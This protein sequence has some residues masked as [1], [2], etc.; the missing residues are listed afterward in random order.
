MEIFQDPSFWAATAFVAFVALTFKP[1][2]KVLGGALDNRSEKI[3]QELEDAARL[4]EEAQKALADYKRKQ[5]EAS[6]EAEE[7]LE[8][9]EVEAARLRVQAEQDLVAALKRREQAA[10]EKIAQAEAKAILEVRNQAVEIAMAA[11]NRLLVE[12]V[13]EA[14]SSVLIQ[15]AIGDLKDKLH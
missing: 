3:R 13:D 6:K 12:S 11:T 14:K 1:I 10:V 7:L 9:T 8:H 4:R 15:D 5:S 2:G